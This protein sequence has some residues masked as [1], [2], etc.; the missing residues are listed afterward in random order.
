MDPGIGAAAVLVGLDLDQRGLSGSGQARDGLGVRVRLAQVVDRALDEELAEL[1]DGGSPGQV[2]RE[3]RPVVGVDGT[4][5]APDG[6]CL[7]VWLGDCQVQ[8]PLECFL[9][10]GA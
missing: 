7:H 2:R 6:T 8:G 10:N 1:P 4:Q 9:E 5:N 3:S